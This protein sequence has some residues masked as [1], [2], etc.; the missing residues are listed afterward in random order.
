MVSRRTIH[1]LPSHCSPIL[2]KV[3]PDS[4]FEIRT[5]T[6]MQ[7]VCLLC[8]LL[9]STPAGQSLEGRGGV[10]SGWGL[11]GQQPAGPQSTSVYEMGNSEGTWC[12]RPLSRPLDRSLYTPQALGGVASSFSYDYY[13]TT[14][15]FL[16][17]QSLNNALTNSLY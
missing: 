1:L 2:N 10:L 11:L 14:L 5:T 4:V 8:S 6:S 15:F 17:F 16:A 3:I 12:P 9:S 7:F 13:V